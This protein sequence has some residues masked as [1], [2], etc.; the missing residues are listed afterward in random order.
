MTFT[1]GPDGKPVMISGT[2]GPNGKPV[3]MA[4]GAGADGRPIV[5][6]SSGAMPGMP[7]MSGPSPDMFE[8]LFLRA[9][10]NG[11]RRITPDEADDRLRQNWQQYDRNNDGGLDQFEYTSY[12]QERFTR[13]RNSRD[14]DEDNDDRNRDRDRDR[15]RDNNPWNQQQGNWGGW[16]QPDRNATQPEVVIQKPVVYRYGKLPKEVPSWFSSLDTD[17]D[18]M[19]G[20]YEWRRDSRKIVEFTGMDLNADGY[21]TAE[22]WLHYNRL[23][24]EKNGTTSNEDGQSTGSERKTPPARFG[25]G[26]DRGGPAGRGV[27]ERGGPGRTPPGGPSKDSPPGRGASRPDRNS[28]NSDNGGPKRG[29]SDQPRRANPFTG[30]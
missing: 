13:G 6:G 24:L 17:K 15:D 30:R 23:T 20:L 26:N 1:S 29:N 28:G 11:D 10:R 14:R 27:F 7:G 18:G 21:L 5:M 4:S 16:N 12:W 2:P 22:E 19:V 25:S 9:D 8:G 3:F